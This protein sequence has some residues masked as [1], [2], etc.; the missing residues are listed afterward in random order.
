[1]KLRFGR[2]LAGKFL[3]NACRVRLSNQPRLEPL[4]VAYFVTFRCNLNCSYCGYQRR[5][6]LKKYKDAGTDDAKRILTICREY[7]PSIGFSG[8]EPLVRED[9]VEIVRHAKSLG[10]KPVSLFTNSLLLPQREEVL[11]EI[12]YLQISLDTVDEAKQDRIGGMPGMGAAVKANVRRY[13]RLQQEKDFQININC[14]LG[15]QN[16]NDVPDLLD[17]ATANDV[18]LTI[19]PELDERGMPVPELTSPATSEKYQGVIDFLLR[20]KRRSKVLMD[21]RPFFEHLRTFRSYDC[22]PTLSARVYPD[23]SLVSP[24]PNL[25]KE[26]MNVLAAGSLRKLMAT[27][28]DKGRQCPQPCFLP[29][30]LETSL[31]VRHPFALLG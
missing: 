7:V 25:S 6:Y 30:Y 5:K 18:R 2:E 31:L 8:G 1:M 21:T 13:A 3:R 26:R 23:G 27:V 28:R 20:E 22:Y 16:I 10:L 11:D 9:M 15:Q 19:C 14:V 12:D 17:F 29:C 24:C 4:V